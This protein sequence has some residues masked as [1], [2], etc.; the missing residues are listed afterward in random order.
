MASVSIIESFSFILFVKVGFLKA[1]CKRGLP[2]T[3]LLDLVCW[4]IN[5][6]PDLLDFLVVWI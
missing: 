1:I 4:S 6:M 5:A 2:F 3:I